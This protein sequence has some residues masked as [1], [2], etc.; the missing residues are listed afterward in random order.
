MK[1]L[2]LIGQKFGRWAVVKDVT[3][4]RKRGYWECACQCGS[5][6][7]VGTASLRCGNSRSCGCYHKDMKT[8]HSMS[9]SPEYKSWASMWQRCT[10]KKNKRYMDYGG[11]G[12]SICDEWRY[13]GKFFLDMG[14]R[15]S[16]EYS[17]DR[18]NNNGNYSKDNCKWSTRSEQQ[19]NRRPVRK[20]NKHVRG[21]D[22]WT[23]K[24]KKRSIAIARVNIKNAH[25]SGEKNS[26]S[27]MTHK[28]ASKMRLIFKYN[29]MIGM[30]NLGAIFGVKRE[31]ARKVIKGV[32]W[33]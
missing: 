16:L 13:F 14:R 25:G 7:V 9:S 6:R 5:I 31:T 29:P 22:H 21:D 28:K 2:N 26:N 15:P 8:T 19:N 33:L 17:I 32:A 30:N 20:D 11:R 18:I 12:I 27:K 23:R 1:K 10:N 4:S 24:D 3:G